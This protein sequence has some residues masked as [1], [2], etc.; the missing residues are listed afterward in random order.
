LRPWAEDPLPAG[1]ELLDDEGGEVG[2]GG[3]RTS[4]PNSSSTTWRSTVRLPDSGDWSTTSY[5]MSLG[6]GSRAKYRTS[7]ERGIPPGSVKTLKPEP[8]VLP[9]R[10]Y[11]V[12]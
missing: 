2:G 6:S 9:T 5:A 1:P 3:D 11:N 4:S 7:A 12:P 8:P 10:R